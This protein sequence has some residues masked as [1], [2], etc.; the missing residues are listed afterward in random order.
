[1]RRDQR[2]TQLEFAWLVPREQ[3][4]ALRLSLQ[5]VRSDDSVPFL[6]YRQTMLGVSLIWFLQ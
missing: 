5:S 1:M 3:N 4:T 2:L 6:A